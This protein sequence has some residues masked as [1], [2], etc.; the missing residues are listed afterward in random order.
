MQRE[1]V[2]ELYGEPPNAVNPLDGCCFHPR[3]PR[4]KATCRE[5]EPELREVENGHF[6]AC[7][8]AGQIDRW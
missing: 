5:D 4:A 6:V 2:L 8:L 1:T 3:C 7:H